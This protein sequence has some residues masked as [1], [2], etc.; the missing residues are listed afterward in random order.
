MA[1]R[2]NKDT[3]E[4]DKFVEKIQ[5][6]LCSMTKQWV[7]VGNLLK[8]AESKWG[9]KSLEYRSLLSQCEIKQSKSSKLLQIAKDDRLKKYDNFISTIQSWTTLYLMTTLSD[10]DLSALIERKQNDGTPLQ[11]IDIEEII[12]QKNDD[13]STIFSV[14]LSPEAIDKN[15]FGKEQ[16]QLIA[17]ILTDILNVDGV[18]I[19]QD[20][21]AKLKQLIQKKSNVFSLKKR[22]NFE[23]DVPVSFTEVS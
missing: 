17:E 8:D 20:R 2:R 23:G 10:E 5:F 9:M 11:R 14:K 15:V 7:V 6:H 18:E 12:E 13:L 21:T 22:W 19:S 1:K 16:F 3:S 4:L